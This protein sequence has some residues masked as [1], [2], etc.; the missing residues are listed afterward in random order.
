[1]LVAIE[2][3]VCLNAGDA[4]ILLAL[5]R[6]LKRVFGEAT[7]FVVFD[8]DAEVARRYF[9][10]IEFRPQVS[11]L[12]TVPRLPARGFSS[13][14]VLRHYIGVDT[15]VF[16]ERPVERQ[17]RRVVSIA[18]FVEYK[19][20]RYIIDALAQVQRGGFPVELVMVGQGPLRQEME[21]YARTR[22]AQVTVI[23]RLSQPEIA[24][25]LAS[26]RLY[27]HGSVAL[28]S[29]HAEAF[30]MTNLEAQAVGTPVVAF[31]SGGVAEAMIDGESGDAVPERDVGAM[32][33]AIASLLTDDAKWQSY[34]RSAARMAAGRFDIRK[35]SLALEDYYDVAIAAHRVAHQRQL[36][37][38]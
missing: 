8:S 22:V 14:R 35:Q 25:L 12:L 16:R 6:E 36:I 37:A 17:P 10:E 20:H 7:R 13:D 15:E 34:S 18:R 21:S 26:A 24:D 19:G 29:G 4:A 11:S 27:V 30:G 38:G 23:D 2:N 3:T 33:A 9:P 32:A 5:M 1:M 28:K 31:R